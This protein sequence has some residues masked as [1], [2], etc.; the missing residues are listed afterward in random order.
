MAVA[1]SRGLAVCALLALCATSCSGSGHQQRERK[2]LP[3]T[4]V[5]ESLLPKHVVDELEALTG[6]R[7]F[8]Q[9]Y[10]RGIEPF[11]AH[12]STLQ[13]TQGRQDDQ[14]L[15]RI[16]GDIGKGGILAVAIYFQ[17]ADA[18]ILNPPPKEAGGVVTPYRLGVRSEAYDF[19]ATIYFPCPVDKSPQADKLLRAGLWTANTKLTGQAGRNARITILNAAARNIARQLD[20]LDTANLPETF[21]KAT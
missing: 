15:C 1:R 9:R 19:G 14:E 7:E 21:H 13:A 6:R 2:L 20:C 16:T 5:C 8:T 4:R 10:P 18:E 17:W 3:G 12:L 11:S